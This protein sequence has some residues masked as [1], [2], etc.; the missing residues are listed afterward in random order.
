[1][2]PIKD[3]EA[4]RSFLNGKLWPQTTSVF[5]LDNSIWLQCRPKREEANFSTITFPHIHTAGS[6]SFWID[7][8]CFYV[9][10]SGSGLSKCCDVICV[11]VSNA[12]QN[13]QQ[14]RGRY[15]GTEAALFVNFPARWMEMPVDVTKRYGDYLF[16][17]ESD[18]SEDRKIP[19]RTIRVMYFLDPTYFKSRL[20]SIDPRSWEY[21]LPNTSI[22]SL[23]SRSMRDFVKAISPDAQFYGWS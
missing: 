23:T 17:G 12:N 22:K 16:L 2:A 8:D 1:M 7:P 10:V 9:R 13:F 18:W 21:F 11:E 14:K 4:K 5:S 20:T 3:R 15:L 6:E 19:V